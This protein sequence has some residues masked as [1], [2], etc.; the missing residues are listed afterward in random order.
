MHQGYVGL[1]QRVRN[2]RRFIQVLQV[3][4]RHGFADLLRRSGV[5]RS[6][7]VRVLRRIHIIDAPEGPPATFGQRLRAALTELGPTFIK[8]GQVL[9]TR[10]DLIGT[11]AAGE[12]SKLQDNVEP[13]PFYAMAPMLEQAFGAPHDQLFSI[14]ETTP[15]ASASLSQVYRARLKS[16]E[17]VAV[18]IQRPGADRIIDADIGLLRQI[19]AWVDEHLRELDWLDA[20]GI[21]E[22]FCRSVRREL[23]FDLEAGIIEQFQ[24]NFAE[25]EDIIIPKI[26]PALCASTVLTMDWIDGVRA[27]RFEEYAAR[28][29]DRP[30]IARRGCEIVCDMVFKY[31]LFHADP[32][33]GNVFITQDNHFALLDYGMAGHLEKADVAVFADLFVAMFHQNSA[34]CVEAVLLLTQGSEPEDREAFQHEIADFI[35]FEARS[36]ISSGQVARG[37]DRA[38]EILQHFQLRLAPRFSLLLKGLATI[39]N[40]GRHLDPDL[41]MVTI[42]Q[43]YVERLVAERY[44]P[45]QILK[46]L[47]QNAGAVRRFTQQVPE[48]FAQI[49]RQ[50]RRGRLRVNLR[51]DDVANLARAVNRAAAWLALGV[52]AGAVFAGSSILAVQGGTFAKLG[53][54]GLGVATALGVM[55][56]ASVFKNRKQ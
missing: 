23:D 7:P 28:N 55:L 16:G 18:K 20:P 5:E 22:E 45:A 53:I 25:Y 41:D 33:P 30:T 24:R 35:A 4:V 37:L 40:V 38:M 10:P 19:A 49:T 34:E 1:G 8:F 56:L 17:L 43:P 11:R 13:L 42:L 48:D 2:A 26:Y 31:R 36:I 12:L 21:V 6:L 54:F 50:M 15:V 46:E 9:S 3:L 44:K 47:Q 39:E 32:H 14:F 27:D 51:Q 29:C 52:F